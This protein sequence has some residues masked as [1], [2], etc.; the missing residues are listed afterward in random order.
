MRRVTNDE[1]PKVIEYL[2]Q[3]IDNCVY[4]YIDAKTYDIESDTVCLWLMETENEI[5]GAVMKYYDSFQVYSRDLGI[6]IK[7]IKE[8]IDEYKVSMISG[9]KFIIE[10]LED[11]CNEYEAIYGGVFEC[12]P[13]ENP[14]CDRLVQKAKEEDAREIAELLCGDSEFSKNYSVDVLARQLEDRIRCGLGRSYYIRDGGEIVAHVATFA[15]TDNIAV[16]SGAIVDRK[17]RKGEYYIWISDYMS[18]KLGIEGKRMY[19]FATQKRVVAYLSEFCR[20]CGQYGKLVKR[21]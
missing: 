17:Y 21:Q 4:M 12:Y 2:N 16:V 5:I 1:K 6:D 7:E 8:L 10:K 11:E 20:F 13:A 15:E 18:W 3:D 14:C 19:A 9:P